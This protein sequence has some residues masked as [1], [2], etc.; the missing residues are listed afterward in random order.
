MTPCTCQAL[1]PEKARAAFLPL[2][3]WPCSCPLY[4]DNCSR[5]LLTKLNSSN[6]WDEGLC[7]VGRACN[8]LDWLF[9]EFE[10]AEA[11][12]GCA[13]DDCSSSVVQGTCKAVVARLIMEVSSSNREGHTMEAKISDSTSSDGKI[14]SWVSMSS[15]AVGQGLLLCW[16]WVRQ[17]CLNPED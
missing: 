17:W 3:T 16:L 1:G 2:P 7:S 5:W 15:N 6:Q 13:Q 9:K 11:V 8:I 10:T 4:F 14:H 12:T